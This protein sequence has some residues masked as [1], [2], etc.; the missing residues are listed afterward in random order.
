VNWLYAILDHE[1]EKVA[2][3]GGERAQLLL[4]RART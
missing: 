4:D 3:C 2:A 1:L